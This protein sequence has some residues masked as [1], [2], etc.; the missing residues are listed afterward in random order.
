MSSDKSKIAEGGYIANRLE[1]YIEDWK[2]SHDVIDIYKTMN[3]NNDVKNETVNIDSKSGIGQKIRE[4]WRSLF[5][6]NA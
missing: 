3:G 1:N 5:G 2:L 6:N 4:K